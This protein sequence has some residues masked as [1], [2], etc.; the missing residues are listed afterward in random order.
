LSLALAF[1]DAIQ[2][3]GKYSKKIQL[4]L[5]IGRQWLPPLQ[6]TEFFAQIFF[7]LTE[8][9]KSLTFAFVIF[10]ASCHRLK[11]HRRRLDLMNAAVLRRT[12]CACRWQYANLRGLRQFSCA[13]STAL[14]RFRQLN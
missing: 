9:Q 3:S 12:C 14:H 2:E 5:A 1:I 6:L 11:G 13:A 4:S 7:R 10:V 8:R